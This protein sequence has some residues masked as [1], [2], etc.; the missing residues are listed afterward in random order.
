MF[1]YLFPIISKDGEGHSSFQND[2]VKDIQTL[3]KVIPCCDLWPCKLP[4]TFS[5]QEAHPTAH[6]EQ[7][8]NPRRHRLDACRREGFDAVRIFGV[9]GSQRLCGTC[10]LTR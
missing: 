6:F 8:R 4:H 3:F 9:G 10:A 5:L 7:N 2:F 1:A